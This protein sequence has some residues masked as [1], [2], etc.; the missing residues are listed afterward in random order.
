MSLG[1]V[2]RPK[3]LGIFV[4]RHVGL[5]AERHDAGGNFRKLRLAKLRCLRQ[6]LDIQGSVRAN[7][8]QSADRGE[9]HQKDAQG[10][11]DF[12]ERE[13]ASPTAGTLG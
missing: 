13:P 4:E 10:N 7:R 8:D 12:Q 6:L 5:P 3:K 9:R 11:Q 2:E 1:S